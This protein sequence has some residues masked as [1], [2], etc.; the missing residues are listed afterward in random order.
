MNYFQIHVD[1]NNGHGTAT[2]FCRP[3]VN[4]AF[5]AGVGEALRYRR[6]CGYESPLVSIY[7]MCGRCKGLGSVAAARKHATKRCPECRGKA[8]R[9][10][11]YRASL[12]ETGGNNEAG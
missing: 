5:T 8:E 4:A 9:T 11:I 12:P 10:V 1:A 3:T 7:E 2:M 6:D